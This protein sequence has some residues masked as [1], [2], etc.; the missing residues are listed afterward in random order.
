[1]SDVK[2]ALD[3]ALERAE[4]LGKATPEELAEWTH[5]PGG[6]RLAARFLK[7]E[8]VD[9]KAEGSKFPPSA[10]RMVLQAMEGVLLAN[11]DVPRTPGVKATALRAIE[12]IRA[13]K[14]DR[15]RL[16]PLLAGIV[17][18]LQHYETAGLQQRQQAYEQ[19]RQEFQAQVP[20]AQAQAAQ[21]RSGKRGQQGS[22]PIEV[23]ALPE[24]A[25]A[26]QQ[27]QAQFDAQYEK[28]LRDQKEAVRRLH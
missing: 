10:Q 8:Q 26:W 13:L 18:T 11:I 23:E 2:S 7:G 17:N 24:F 5:R 28:V 25:A 16:E 20:A 19:L 22:Q 27:V 1:M 15:K 4:K 12:G 9:L 6:E 21:A 3:K 14:T